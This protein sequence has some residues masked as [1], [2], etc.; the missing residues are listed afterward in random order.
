MMSCQSPPKIVEHP[1]PLHPC[2]FDTDVVDLARIYKPLIKATSSIE[3]I[4]LRQQLGRFV[5]ATA[6]CQTAEEKLG[7]R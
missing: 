6:Y 4:R 1:P 3:A 7:G 5:D 2:P